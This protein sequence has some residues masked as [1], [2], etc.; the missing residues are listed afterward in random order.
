M[1]VDKNVFSL[2]LVF[3]CVHVSVKRCFVF[4]SL[5]LLF[6]YLVI[7]WFIYLSE[8]QNVK[9]PSGHML[10][11]PDQPANL[12]RDFHIYMQSKRLYNFDPLKPHFYIVRLGLTGVYII[13]LISAQKHRLWVLVRTASAR[14][15]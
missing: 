9:V 10:T 7:H 2:L 5:F 6:L 8:T 1:R 14:R 11:A 4:I 12:M 15:F 13:F 3:V